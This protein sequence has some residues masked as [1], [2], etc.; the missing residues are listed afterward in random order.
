MIHVRA[1]VAHLP[2][3][4]PALEVEEGTVVVTGALDDEWPA[5]RW[6]IDED[7]VAGWV[8]DR[9]LRHEGPGRARCARAYS[10]RELA[11]DPGDVLELVTRDD[12]SGWHWCRDAA[13]RGGWVPARALLEVSS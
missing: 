4:R 1:T 10:T 3:D 9:H 8:P 6:C 11:V 12:E 13:R 2:P 7:G 5:F